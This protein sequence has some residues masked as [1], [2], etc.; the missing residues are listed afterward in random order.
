MLFDLFDR[1]F[2]VVWLHFVPVGLV[3]GAVG[4]G[5]LCLDPYL[6]PYEVTSVWI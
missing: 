4:G 5:C 1:C 2:L 6:V 3:V